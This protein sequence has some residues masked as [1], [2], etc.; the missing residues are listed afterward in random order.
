[1]NAAAPQWNVSPAECVTES[2]FVVDPAGT[3]KLAYGD[4]VEAASGLDIPQTG[5]FRVKAES[6]YRYMGTGIGHWDAPSIVTGKAVYGF[7]TKLPGMLY[8]TIARCPVFDGS[9]ASYDDSKALA[10]PGVRSVYQFEDRIAVVAEN[11]WAAIKG[12]TA[13]EIEW[14]EG[15][16]ADLSSASIREALAGQTP[17]LGSA[18]EGEIEAIYEFPYQAHATMEPM[19]CAAHVHD[20]IC[21][22]W[23]PTQSPQEVQAQVAR[24]TGIPRDSVIVNVTLIGGGFGR[25]LEAD[26]A[27][28]AALVS[29][30]AEAPVQT[31]WT[32][33]DDMRH[34]F[35]HP[36]S[37]QYASGNPEKI[38][39]PRIRSTDGGSF[40]PT[41]A[42]RSVGEH[43]AAYARECFLDEL[44]FAAGVD[45]LDYRREIYSGRA[46][47]VIELAAEKAGWGEPLPEGWGRGI[48]YHATFGVTHVCHVAEVEVTPEGQVRV[49]RVVCAVDCGIVVNPDTVTAQ[50]ESGITFGLTAALKAGITLEN[51]RVQQSNFHD[52]PML[53]IAEMP[54]VEVHIVES[55]QNPSGIGE[56][57]VPPIAPAVANAIFDATGIRVRH[58][59]IR[60]EDL[61]EH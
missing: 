24:Y 15:H 46:L 20:G 57:G 59:P 30:L 4:L 13:L 12:C 42:W 9:V 53:T 34:D 31:V 38:Q 23:A 39:L 33:D 54:V 17:G 27:V 28:E 47:A 49:Q 40:I 52:C 29:T 3:E 7:D 6:D 16:N 43:P 10:V 35:Y 60:A 1:V 58:L 32:R 25:R 21:E 55:I 14:N 48:G 2:G 18:A 11:T 56:M 5:E 61:L 36:F 44:A 45:P 19:N 37:Y 22:L 8:A 51:G 41:G 50:M 26:Y